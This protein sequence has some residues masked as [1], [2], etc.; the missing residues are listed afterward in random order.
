MGDLP[1]YIAELVDSYPQLEGKGDGLTHT[2]TRGYGVTEEAYKNLGMPHLTDK[3]AATVLLMQ[4]N[5]FLSKKLQGFSKAPS[6]V[7]KAILDTAY[8]VGEYN[9][10]KWPGLKN[11]LVKKDW[12]GVAYNLLDTANVGKRKSLGLGKRRAW[13]ANFIFGAL[14]SRVFHSKVNTEMANKFLD[15]IGK[16][17]GAAFEKLF[18]SSSFESR[19]IQKVELKGNKMRYLDLDGGTIF[20][21]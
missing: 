14:P 11:R 7:K 2:P 18:G 4:K 8:N 9:I 21:Y 13:A 19:R 1:T 17:G 15:V 12:V 20:E 16:D 6:I 3:E 5:T 10:I